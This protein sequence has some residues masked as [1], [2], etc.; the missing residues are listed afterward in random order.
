MMNLNILIIKNCSPEKKWYSKERK[1]EEEEKNTVS[2][3]FFFRFSLRP[4]LNENIFG[5]NENITKL[6]AYDDIRFFF[7]I[8]QKKMATPFIFCEEKKKQQNWKWIKEA[9][10][11]VKKGFF[12][13]SLLIFLWW[14]IFFSRLRMLNLET[15]T[16]SD[17]HW[18]MAKWILFTDS[19]KFFLFLSN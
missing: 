14:S 15:S 18:F 3:E 13:L 11:M 19:E 2:I 10:V 1:G 7:L 17:C 8:P 9:S 6:M 4:I 12:F 5:G 16:I